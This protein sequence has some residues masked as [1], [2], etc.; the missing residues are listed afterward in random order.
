MRNYSIL[1]FLI[2][3][4][5]MTKIVIV[6][7]VAISEIFI[8][9]LAP[10]LF[11]KNYKSLRHDGFLPVLLLLVLTMCGCAIATIVNGSPMFRSIKVLA[12]YYSIFSVIV[13]FHGP[14]SKDPKSL[15]WFLLGAFIS[16]LITIFAFNASLKVS[17]T[18]NLDVQEATV[19]GVLSGAMFW[20]FQLQNAL[21]AFVGGFYT[22]M[23]YLFSVMAPV[24]AVVIIGLTGISGRALS[25]CLLGGWLLIVYCG[26]NTKRMRSVSRHFIS[27]IIVGILAIILFKTT[28]SHLARSGI[29]GEEAMVKYYNQTKTGDSILRLLMRGRVEFFI[30][31]RAAI[32]KPFVGYGIYPLDTKGYIQEYIL[33]YGDEQDLRLYVHSLIHS[34]VYMEHLIPTHSYLVGS[35]VFCGIFGLLLWLYVL[36]L[37]FM[38]FKRW[39][40]AI[41]QWFGYFSL[42]IP[43]LV[44]DIF[45]SPITNRIMPAVM[46]AAIL[47]AKAVYEGRMN[48]Y[49]EIGTD[50]ARR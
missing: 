15:K 4:G 12:Q 40:A 11:V 50:N 46:I 1:M 2:G 45:F 20:M 31:L 22:E 21:N 36:Y 33:K 28:Y 38:Y 5:A 24:V 32:D 37:C 49:Y 25:L 13:F 26:K 23:P 9:S 16:G 44:W 42:G 43:I 41:P 6:G 10:I 48:N 19:E 27:F 34:G 47:L 3:L 29:L 18:G 14:L 17:A 30:G 8:L 35:W 7:S 39:I